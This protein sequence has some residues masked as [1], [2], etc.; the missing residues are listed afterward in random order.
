[1]NE[2]FF[3]VE[4]M[5]TSKGKRREVKKRCRKFHNTKSHA[6]FALNVKRKKKLQIPRVTSLQHCL[7]AMPSTNLTPKCLIM[8]QQ[9]LRK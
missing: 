9:S 3:A 7:P 1:M 8:C 2:A 6:Q 4:D 5:Q